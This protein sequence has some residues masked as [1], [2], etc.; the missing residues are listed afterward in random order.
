MRLV[1]SAT[2]RKGS[3]SLKVSKIVQKIYQDMNEP[4]KVLD[5][6]TISFEDILDDPYPKKLP[7]KINKVVDRVAQSSSLV[8]VCPEYNGSFPG[9]FKFFLDHWRFPESFEYKPVCLIGIGSGRFGGLRPVE[10]LENLFTYRKSFISPSKVLISKIESV[11]QNGEIR[12]EIV[13]NLLTKQAKDFSLF[14][15]A[16][17]T[18]KFIN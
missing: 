14:T 13:F 1:I 8:I 3:Y 16:L 9:I 2:N 7:E 17:K 10:H 11:V 5:L 12:D 18:E 6:R 15:K 4:C